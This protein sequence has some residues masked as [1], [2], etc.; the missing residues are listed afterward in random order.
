MHQALLFSAVS[1]FPSVFPACS[2]QLASSS[3]A[4]AS[5]LPLKYRVLE[6]KHLW[7]L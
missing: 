1:C 6:W 5:L 7:A 2:A 4:P 3:A